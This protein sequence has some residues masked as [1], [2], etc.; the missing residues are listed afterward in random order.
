MVNFNSIRFLSTAYDPISKNLM[1]TWVNALDICNDNGQIYI[2]GRN[3]KK[4]KLFLV[5]IWF[6]HVT[7][8]LVYLFSLCC[9]NVL[10]KDYGLKIILFIQYL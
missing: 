5:E 4:K 7:S 10:I 1:C 2:S 6:M 3:L 8:H 9:E